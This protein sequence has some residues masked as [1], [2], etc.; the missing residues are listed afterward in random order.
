MP[1]SDFCGEVIQVLDKRLSDRGKMWRHCYKSLIVVEFLFLNG[2]H[3]TFIRYYTQN[4][5]L[6][7]TLQEYQYV[8]S[9][10]IDRGAAVRDRARVV[11]RMIQQPTRGGDLLNDLSS[12]AAGG[13]RPRASSSAAVAGVRDKKPVDMPSR[14]R[15]KSA[16]DTDV[17]LAMR[18]SREEDEKRRRE[19]A[20]QSHGSIFDQFE[21]GRPAAE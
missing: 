16:P 10:G 8:D 1:C 12:A 17:A 2:A 5:Y 6:V 14:P 3:R 21:P 13:S 19:L 7:K 18:L 11:T 20:A 4:V 15:A 9:A